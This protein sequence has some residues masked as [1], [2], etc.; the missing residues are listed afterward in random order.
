MK[1]QA[2]RL[3]HFR[4]FRVKFPKISYNVFFNRTPTV[5]ACGKW[6]AKQKYLARFKVFETS[7]IKQ[8]LPKS[9]LKNIA[10]RYTGD[11]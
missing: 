5:A 2:F 1:L 11:K 10:K 8:P 7:L 9:N 6:Y 4:C 3:K